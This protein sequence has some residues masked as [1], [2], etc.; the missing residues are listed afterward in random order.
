MLQDPRFAV[1]FIAPTNKPYVHNLHK[2]VTDFLDGGFDF[3][4][5]LDDDNP[6]QRN[7]LDLCELDLDVV[8]CPTP[9]WH[10]D[11]SRPD[12]RPYYF[13]ALREVVGED[14]LA[15]FKPIDSDPGFRPAG[16]QKCDAVGTGCVVIARRVLEKLADQALERGPQESPFF[17]R[18]D[19]HGHVVMGNDYAFCQRVRAAGFSVYAHFDYLCEHLNEIPVLEAIQAF[20][21]FRL[22]SERESP[23]AR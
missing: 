13:N 16:L 2:V 15:G 4:V 19:N 8:G 5:S 11:T 18:W 17:R 6:P 21:A 3:L 1:T 9:V 7:P 20:M 22:S 10:C 14:G 12:D 23:A